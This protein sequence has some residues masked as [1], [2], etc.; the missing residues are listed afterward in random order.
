MLLALSN[1]KKISMSVQTTSE[2]FIQASIIYH[3][4]LYS[5][6]GALGSGITISNDIH[7]NIYK[8]FNLI[9]RY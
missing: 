1:F 8:H 9:Y 3:V 4:Y 5:G 7:I 2:L 6:D